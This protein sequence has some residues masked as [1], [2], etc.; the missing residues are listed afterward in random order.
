[1]GVA[2]EVISGRVTA[3][4]AVQTA[5][6]MNGSDSLSVRNTDLSAKIWLLEL[7]AK[8]QAAGILRVRSPKLH[9]NVQ[10]LRYRIPAS[11]VVPRLADGYP[12]QLYPQD[13][14]VADLSGSA[15]AGQIEEAALL[16]YY[17]DLPGISARLIDSAT[18]K[19]RMRNLVTQEIA[20]VSL[21]TGDYGTARALN[22]D[23]DLLKANTDYAVLGGYGDAR[24]AVITLRGADTG[25]LRVGLPVE[26]AIRDLTAEW[27][28]FLSDINH[29]PL[30]PVINSANK[31]GIFAEAITDQ[32][33]GT[34]N[35]T[36][37]LAELSP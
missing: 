18:V 23:F 13:T 31:A 2:L 12:Q 27:F 22:A 20:T 4:G 24:A 8:N 5:L 35:S 17:A 33:A 3:P 14:L 32:G 25:N 30:V 7:W 26:S 37:N 34:V 16:I 11:E 10:G 15:V 1:M 6:T 9:D 28:L 19:S 21:A 29:L 36:W